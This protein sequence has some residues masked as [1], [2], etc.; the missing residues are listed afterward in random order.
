MQISSRTLS[1]DLILPTDAIVGASSSPKRYVNK[2]QNMVVQYSHKV[3][4][5]ST[6]ESNILGEISCR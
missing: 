5:V 2:A 3:I 4:P 6:K 1:L